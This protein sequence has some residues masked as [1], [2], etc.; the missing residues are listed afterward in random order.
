MEWIVHRQAWIPFLGSGPSRYACYYLVNYIYLVWLRVRLG[1][2]HP[3]FSTREARCGPR[4]RTRSPSACTVPLSL[5]HPLV[6]DPDSF[7]CFQSIDGI[8]LKSISEL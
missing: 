6:L 3:R 1:D 4:V 5:T 8:V 2:L 7:P